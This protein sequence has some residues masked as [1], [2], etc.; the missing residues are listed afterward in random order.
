M[1]REGEVLL[2]GEGAADELAERAPVF[3]PLVERFGPA[4][5]EAGRDLFPALVEAICNQQLS[6]QA[7]ASVFGKLEVLCDGD[8]RPGAIL[9]APRDELRGC[10]L[11]G[12][13]TGY[14]EDLAGKV[15]AGELPVDELETMDDEAVVEVL[16]EVEGIGEWTAQMVLIFTLHRP[17]V[18][19]TGDLGVR[20]GARIVLD[21]DDEPTPGQLEEIAEDWRP[22]RSL[23][24]WYL[25]RERDRRLRDA[26]KR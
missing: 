24:S 25:W 19:P 11:S 1:L 20:D 17:D 26:G 22:Y 13:K 2:G 10:G 7:G 3:A 6:V 18:L 16:T 15:R 5:V 23:A 8:V 12:P 9:D 14:V 21:L 4:L